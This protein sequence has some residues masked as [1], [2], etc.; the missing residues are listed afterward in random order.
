MIYGLKSSNDKYTKL[1]YCDMNDPNGYKD[2]DNNMESLIGY[3]EHFEDPSDIVVDSLK[4]DFQKKYIEL[5]QKF[6]Q[7]NSELE[8]MFGELEEKCIHLQQNNNKL[9][10]NLKQD[11]QK[12][13]KE[14]EQTNQKL[15][16]R[17]SQK[18]SELENMYGELEEKN[19]Q[20]QQNDNKINENLSALD[21]KITS[22][23]HIGNSNK[24]SVPKIAVNL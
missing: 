14:L 20:L 19:I 15:E 23:S 3:V 1:A 4:Q 22:H 10:E 7:K 11:F 9:N 18:I 16:Q 21:N 6:F 24:T 8:N 17:F 13:Y 12:K 5:E 2:A